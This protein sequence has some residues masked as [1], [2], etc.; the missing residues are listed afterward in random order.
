MVFNQFVLYWV[1][2]HPV[3]LTRFDIINGPDNFQAS[4]IRSFHDDLAF[5]DQVFDRLP[6]IGLNGFVYKVTNT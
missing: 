2:S 1:C 4:G 5:L 3:N 6:D